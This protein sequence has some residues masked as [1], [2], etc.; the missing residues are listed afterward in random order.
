MRGLACSRTAAGGG[1]SSGRALDADSVRYLVGQADGG[2]VKGKGGRRKREERGR[3]RGRGKGDVE[4][5][6]SRVSRLAEGEEGREGEKRN[7]QERKGDCLPGR[8]QS[9]NSCSW[10]SVREADGLDCSVVLSRGRGGGGS[11]G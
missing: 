6:D 1:D 5:A 10:L 2:H 9:R 4:R 11:A 8:K 3:G 7:G